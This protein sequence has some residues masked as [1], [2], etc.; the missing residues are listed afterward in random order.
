[1]SAIL[2]LRKENDGRV[3]GDQG[4]QASN[5]SEEDAAGCQSSSSPA[6]S[7]TCSYIVLSLFSVK[8]AEEVEM[9]RVQMPLERASDRRVSCEVMTALQA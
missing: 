7:F 3:A 4:E 9:G 1:M 8:R 5:G 2:K 6:L